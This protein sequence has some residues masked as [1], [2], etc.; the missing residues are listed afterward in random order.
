MNVLHYAAQNDQPWPIVYFHR[1]FRMNVDARDNDGNAALHWAAYFGAV[2]ALSCLLKWTRCVN[3]PNSEGKTPL[4][5]GTQTAMSSGSFR[6]IRLLCFNGADRNLLD[7]NGKRAIDYVTE[8]KATEVHL[9]TGMGELRN[10]LREQNECLCL[11]LKVPY[12]K[13]RNSVK[14]GVIFLVFHA[15]REFLI[16]FFALPRISYIFLGQPANSRLEVSLLVINLTLLV[17]GIALF[18]ISAIKDPGVHRREGKRLLH[19]IESVDFDRICPVCEIVRSPLTRH[20]VICNK[21]VERYDHHCPWIGSCV[22]VRNHNYF[23]ALL[24]TVFTDF[25]ISICLSIMASIALL[26][27]FNHKYCDNNLSAIMPDVVCH[28][29]S[30]NVTMLCGVAMGTLSIVLVFCAL[31]TGGLCG[32]QVCNYCAGKT[33]NERFGSSG[34]SR[35]D[36]GCPRNCLEFCKRTIV[37][38][39][40]YLLRHFGKENSTSILERN[41]VALLTGSVKG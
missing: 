29:K 30:Y 25:M 1:E 23:F 19:L 40:S 24:I 5:L 8:G 32:V 26:F 20:C 15:L 16:D 2:D 3:E 17:L 21:C 28:F 27:N 39:Q 22:G 41:E 4:H 18:F 33:T 38:S 35:R 14:L 34:S 11:M 10:I 6:A 31:F 7:S 13:I 37:P 36:K 12:K 9:E